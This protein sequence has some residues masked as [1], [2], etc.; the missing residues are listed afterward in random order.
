M[1][2]YLM[3]ALV[4]VLVGTL[5]VGALATGKTGPAGKSKVGHLYLYEKD[6]NWDI[7][8]D[9]GAW[10][11]MKYN[12]SGS[13]F[14]FVFNAHGLEADTDYTLIYY[15][16]PWPG[17]GLICL[18]SGTANDYADVHIM[19]RVD[20]GD[21]PAEADENDGA[22]IWLVLSNDVDCDNHLMTG[23]TPAEY[24]FEY[25]LITFDD[26]DE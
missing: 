8:L 2:K 6:A 12:T 4:V 26:T 22:K 13:T 10:G 1:K 7:V 15:P 17:S 23:W 3:F 21:L 14:N 11:K 25:D 24:L 20:T 18:G 16:D 19:G 5:A 9:G